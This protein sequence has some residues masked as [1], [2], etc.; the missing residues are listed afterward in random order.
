VFDLMR[1][2]EMLCSAKSNV[3]SRRAIL[4]IPALHTS[5]LFLQQGHPQCS[6]MIDASLAIRMVLGRPLSMRVRIFLRPDSAVAPFITFCLGRN[7][8]ER[9]AWE[10]ER[11]PWAAHVPNQD[12]AKQRGCHRQG[13]AETWCNE[14]HVYQQRL[15]QRRQ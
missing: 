6:P 11:R 1:V 12:V 10:S 7:V 4:L 3:I 13:E 15:R 5:N 8:Q 9:T 2:V 14:E